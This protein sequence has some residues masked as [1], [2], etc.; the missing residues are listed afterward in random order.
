MFTL[1][2]YLEDASL[3]KLLVDASGEDCDMS[4]QDNLGN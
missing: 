1:I 2:N 4:G 3:E